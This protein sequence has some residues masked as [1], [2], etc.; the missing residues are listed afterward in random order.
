MNVGECYHGRH[1]TETQQ[2]LQCL[3]CKAPL[4]AKAKLH[5]PM[6]GCEL[7]TTEGALLNLIQEEMTEIKLIMH[8]LSCNKLSY[9][10]SIT[11]EGTKSLAV[12]LQKLPS[13]G[14]MQIG[15]F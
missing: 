4:H 7:Q 12:C 6:G 2:A 13:F 14:Y 10:C 15:E 8:C 5:N 3:L 1:V 9:G 11:Q